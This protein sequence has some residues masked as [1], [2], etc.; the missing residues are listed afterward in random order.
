VNKKGA[1]LVEVAITLPL[2]VMIVFGFIYFTVI[3]KETLVIQTA[4]REGARH[5]AVYH[6]P[7]EAVAIAEEELARG[8]VSGA[9][10]RP[11]FGYDYRGVR[12]EKDIILSIP[13]GEIHMFTIAREVT[14][15]PAARQTW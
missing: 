9:R 11:T 6:K 2:L 15:H 8:G 7:L 4:A 1:A 5:H 13:F 12:V 3:M 10:T 14:I